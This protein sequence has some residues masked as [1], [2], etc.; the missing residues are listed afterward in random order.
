M[1]T[2]SPNAKNNR[3]SARQTD[4]KFGAQIHNPDPAVRLEGGPSADYRHRQIELGPGE[5]EDFSELADGEVIDGI[6]VNRDEDGQMVLIDATKRINLVELAPDNL[7]YSEKLEWLSF[8]GQRT[9]AFFRER[10]SA[11]LAD[12]EDGFE[13]V[14]ATTST[15]VPFDGL[16]PTLI[17]DSAW[18]SGITR[19]H[20]EYDSGT[21]GSENMDRL[22]REACVEPPVHPMPAPNTRFI[23][24]MPDGTTM[25]NTVAELSREPRPGWKREWNRYTGQFVVTT[26]EHE[27]WYFTQA[28]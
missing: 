17:A 6:V 7:T 21:F 18:N 16:T 8:N 15:E 23:N 22:L 25:H 1:T 26:P 4:G 5:Q 27:R 14:Y 9:S 28:S 12:G 2:I 11:T 20:N 10:Y 3:E 24:S 19:I 13:E